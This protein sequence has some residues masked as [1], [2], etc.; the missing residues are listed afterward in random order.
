MRVIQFAGSPRAKRHKTNFTRKDSYADRQ[1]GRRV[2]PG[3]D[4]V[5]AAGALLAFV[6]SHGASLRAKYSDRTTTITKA[7]KAQPLLTAGSTAIQSVGFMWPP[8]AR[9]RPS[10]V[11][12]LGRAATHPVWPELKERFPTSTVDDNPA[13]RHQRMNFVRLPPVSRPETR[14]KRRKPSFRP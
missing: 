6:I 8:R 1:H 12:T 4:D 9:V 10:N 14:E 11:T 5:R 13:H 7:A 2:K 3:G